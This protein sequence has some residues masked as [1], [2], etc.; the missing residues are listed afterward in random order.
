MTDIAAIPTISPQDLEALR[1]QPNVAIMDVRMP[2]D[3]LGG[4]IP[5]AINMPGRAFAARRAQVSPELT[6]IFVDADGADTQSAAEALTIGYSKVLVLDGGYEA[7]LAADLP[8]DDASEGI[9][10]AIAVPT[11]A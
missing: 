7:W 9:M 5:N 6:L 10:P 1:S 11:K 3:Y 4:R 8:T 2:F